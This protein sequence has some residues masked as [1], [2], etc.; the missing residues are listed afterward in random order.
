MTLGEVEG[1]GTVPSVAAPDDPEE[2][3]PEVLPGEPAP[4]AGILEPDL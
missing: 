4:G 2:V 3:V 1:G